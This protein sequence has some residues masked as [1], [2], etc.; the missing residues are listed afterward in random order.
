ME[1]EYCLFCFTTKWYNCVSS[2][3]DEKEVALCVK[4]LNAPSFY[5]QV[6]S[7]WA[8]DSFDRK[9]QE[10]D[11]LAKPPV[12]LSKSDGTFNPAQLIEG[13]EKFFHCSSWDRNSSGLPVSDP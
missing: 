6:L 2:A 9:D 8:A 7:A 11:M 5:P 12:S 13:L 1:T 3:K 4:D 10:R